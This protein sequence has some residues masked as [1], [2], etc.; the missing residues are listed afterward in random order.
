MQAKSEQNKIQG[1]FWA[2]KC[3]VVSVRL[4]NEQL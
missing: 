3:P 2:Q 1:L 4:I